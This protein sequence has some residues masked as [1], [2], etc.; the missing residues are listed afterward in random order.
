MSLD[1]KVFNH[2]AFLVAYTA[3]VWRMVEDQEDA[4]TLS[5]VDTMDEQALLEQLL[6]EVKPPYREGTQGMSYLFKTAFRYPPLRHGSRFGTRL[7]PSYFYA[8]EKSITAQAETAY[9]RFVFLHDM[10][11]PYEKE[12]DSKHSM[13]S[14]TVSAKRCLD[15][16]SSPYERYREQLTDPVNYQ[17]SQAVGSWAV[18]QREVQLI[19]AESAR[20]SSTYNLAIADPA[21]IRSRQPNK[22]ES[23]LCRTTNNSVS[24]SSRQATGVITFTLD[25]FSVD[26][27]LP[28]P[29]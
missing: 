8:S 5:I 19:R 4:A 23:W 27:V 25:D 3:K 2:D 26:G 12:I 22:I 21:V 28:R 15:L 14:A 29:A 24:F 7:M 11:T 9:Y 16:A 6:D 20:L 1:K 17:F 18:N 10:Q 13:F